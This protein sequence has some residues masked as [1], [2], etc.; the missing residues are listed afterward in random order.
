MVCAKF[1]AKCVDE[2]CLR[3]LIEPFG[4]IVKVLMFPCLVSVRG[5]PAVCV[6]VLPVGS[7]QCASVTET[8]QVRL[9]E[10]HPS[11]LE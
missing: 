9:G 8:S 11:P 1:E 3:T 5:S 6:G 2:A 7:E 10:K 4:K